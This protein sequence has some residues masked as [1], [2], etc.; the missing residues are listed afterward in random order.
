MFLAD[1]IQVPISLSWILMIPFTFLLPSFTF[2]LSFCVYAPVSIFHIRRT[3]RPSL[4]RYDFESNKK[5]YPTW[6]NTHRKV[7]LLKGFSKEERGKWSHLLTRKETK[8]SSFTLFSWAG[9]WG[10]KKMLNFPYNANFFYY[11]QGTT[12]HRRI[13]LGFWCEGQKDKEGITE[14]SGPKRRRRFGM[15]GF[16][17][18]VLLLAL[19]GMPHGDGLP[20]GSHHLIPVRI[21]PSSGFGA[22]DDQSQD[23]FVAFL[24]RI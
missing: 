14:R 16:W 20:K 22:Q 4:A 6:V 17:Q 23:P 12:Y 7:H 15:R 3:I 5:Q 24:L 19:N 8:T 18:H 11:S 9:Y 2:Q 21:G 13:C 10:M 1:I